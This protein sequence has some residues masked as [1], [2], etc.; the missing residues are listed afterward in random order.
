MVEDHDSPGID[1]VKKIEVKVC[2]S[3]ETKGNLSV[4]VFDQRTFEEDI[5]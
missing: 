5:T 3:S 4:N 1:V 2:I